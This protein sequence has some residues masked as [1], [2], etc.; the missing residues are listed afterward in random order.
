M[1]HLT[2]E[3]PTGPI[4]IVEA[5]GAIVEIRWADPDEPLGG[6][7]TPLL[8]DAR[9]ELSEYFA[10]QRRRFELPVRTA[11]SALQEAVWREMRAIP[12]GETRTYGDLAAVI[13]SNARL[14][15]GACGSNR[16]PIVIP[17]HRVVGAGGR[18]TGFSGG[19]GT[20]TKRALLALEGAL[21][22]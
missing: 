12:Y 9:R 11:G 1:P 7:Q 16:V 18:L 22:I 21:L 13:G 10:G 6:D 20:E 3:S 14:V 4:R 2:I 17:C 19:C 5:G 8:A 15:G